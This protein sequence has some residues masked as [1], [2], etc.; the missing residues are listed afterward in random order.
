MAYAAYLLSGNYVVDVEASPMLREV[1]M[2]ASRQTPPATS[3]DGVEPGMS[4]ESLFDVWIQ[5]S[6]SDNDNFAPR[7]CLNTISLRFY[8]LIIDSNN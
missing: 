7:C 5:R 8:S 4:P 2:N 1:V 3:F 6:P